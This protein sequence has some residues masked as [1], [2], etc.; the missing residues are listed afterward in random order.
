MKEESQFAHPQKNMLQAGFKPGDRIGEFGAGSGHVALALSGIV[1]NEGRI[2]AIDIQNDVLAHLRD[3][4]DR[5]GIKNI[6]TIHG[7][8]EKA[9]GSHLRDHVL[10]G[11]VLSNVLFQIDSMDGLIAEIQRTL[12]PGG[13]V[14]VTDW[15]GSYGGIG[16][17]EERVV[18]EHRA[19]EIFINAGFH[20]VKSYRAGTHHYSILFT[21]PA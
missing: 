15:A 7:D 11:V 19:E 8:F 2:Y 10:D 5:R 20:K 13:K 1:G 12:K 9:G 3:T 4:M 17:S 6:D 18:S 21:K 16:P 14:L